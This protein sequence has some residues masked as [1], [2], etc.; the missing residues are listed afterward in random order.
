MPRAS[1]VPETPYPRKDHSQTQSVRS[2]DYL[3]VAHRS[4]GLNDSRRAGLCNFFDSVWEGEKSIG[5][6][7]RPFQRKHRLHGSDLARIHAAHL[8]SS[9]AHS[10]S[11]AGIDDS[12]RLYVLADSPGKK[13]SSLFFWRRLPL[14]DHFQIA[15]RERVHIGILQQDSAGDVF[16]HPLLP[17]IVNF[18]QSQVLLGC[19]L[20]FSV[21]VEAG[22]G[23]HFEKELRHLFGR[24]AVDR[25]IHADNASES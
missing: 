14:G 6:S 10:L 20:G 23:D 16:Q 24:V 2:L 18:H 19:E 3:W 21:V 15:F 4:A 7:N 1:S 12:V 17:S 8:P 9:D 13:Q 22:R 11:V 5:G 25:T